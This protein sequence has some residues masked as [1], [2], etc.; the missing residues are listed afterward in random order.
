[1]S[2]HLILGA[3]STVWRLPA[4]VNV[5][6]LRKSI[7]KA[8]RKESV[9]RVK[10]EMSDDPTQRGVVLINGRTIQHVAVLELRDDDPQ[11]LKMRFGGSADSHARF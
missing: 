4:D 11:P 6:A 1:M 5:K 10:I 3:Y 7:Q 9:V 2:K 8:M